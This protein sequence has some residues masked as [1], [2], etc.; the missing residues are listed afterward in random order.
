VFVSYHH[1]NDQDYRDEFEKTFEDTHDIIISSSV[2]IG[3]IDKN[4]KTDTVRKK[5]RDEYLRDST[6]T[7]VLIGSE[8][9]KRKHVDWEIGSSIRQTQHSP[10][11]GLLGI[12]LPSYPRRDP[13][14]YNAH[15]V[16]P[17]LYDNIKCGFAT[18]HNW[19]NEHKLVAKWIHDAFER[20][21]AKIPDNSSEN[22]A[23]NRSG[24]KWQK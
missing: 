11:S 17:R 13:T 24:D 20:R 6:V 21:N 3:E 1:E 14:K 9:W 22:F 15:T 2:R 18:I 10:R 5:I 12:I 19:T 7:V 4:L 16:P 8:T 23:N